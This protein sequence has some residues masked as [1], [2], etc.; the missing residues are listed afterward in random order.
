MI[1]W[2]AGLAGIA[3]LGRW[4]ARRSRPPEE[5]TPLEPVAPSAQAEPADATAAAED[6]AG[7]LRRKLAE[8][9]GPGT[10]SGDSS[11][12]EETLDERR[13]RVHAEARAAIDAMGNGGETQ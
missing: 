4:L 7:E 2:F 11:A 3:A 8:S 9:R 12:G 1:A 13:R 5:A 6:P 10:A